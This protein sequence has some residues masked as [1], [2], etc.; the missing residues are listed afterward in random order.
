[1]NAPVRKLPHYALLIASV[2]LLLLQ[3]ACSSSST[4]TATARATTPAT[5]ADY[6]LGP[7]DSLDVFVWGNPDVSVKSVPIR[8]DG[9]LTTPLAEDVVA[10]GKTPSQLAREIEKI[11]A[12]YIKD[13][14]VTV[15]VVSFVGGYN[16]QVR[17]VGAASEPKALPYREGMTVLDLMIAV[18][19]LTEYADGNAAILIHGA[20]N[21]THKQKVRLDD[22]LRK[23]DISANV[24]LSPGDTLVIPE[25]WF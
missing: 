7:G 9:K 3:G 12:K 5:P 24:R 20:E 17:V 1:M 22:L 21:S 13:P 4:P 15:T 2:M 10:A 23:G 18:G 8:P 6:I 11:L 16:E 14:L 19:G 25:S